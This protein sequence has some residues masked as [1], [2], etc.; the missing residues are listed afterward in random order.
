M[1]LFSWGYQ[2]RSFKDLVQ[3]CKQHDISFIVDVRRRAISSQ[4]GWSKVELEIMASGVGLQYSHIPGLGNYHKALPWEKM[5]TLTVQSCVERVC[6]LLHSG[7][8]VL[9]CKE[10]E[11]EQCHRNEVAEEIRQASG[12]LVSHLGGSGKSK[13]EERQLLLF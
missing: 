1:Q 10:R 13:V 12:C 8:V 5:D 9:I 4:P 11:A 3:V 2:S 6:G 7:N